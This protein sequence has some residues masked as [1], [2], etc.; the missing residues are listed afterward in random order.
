MS[1]ILFGFLISSICYGAISV[2]LTVQEALYSGGLT[3]GIAR[4]SEPITGGVPI[5]DAAGITSI[6]AF[7]LTGATAGQF[8]VEGRWPS[9]NIKW[10]KVRAIVPSVAAGG[11]ATITLTDS[12]GGNFG[13]TNLATDNGASI[14]VATGAA[15]FTVKKAQFNGLDM[16]DIGATHVVL[17]GTSDG[18]VVIGPDATAGY[19]GNV[20]CLPT[21]GGSLCTTLYKSS[22]DPNS[23]CLIEENGPAMAVLKCTADLIDSAAHVYMHLTARL[24][25]YQNK[26]YVRIT[27]ILR[28]ADYGSSGTATVASKGHQGFEL[29]VRP[30]ITGTLNYSIANHTTTPTTGALNQTGGTDN[31]YIYQAE[32]NNLKSAG[33][34][35]N[36]CVGYSSI[37]GYAIVANGSASLTGTAN[38]FPQ[39][40][41]DVSNS[42]GV[43][44]EIGQDQFSGYG[45]KS[46]EFRNGGNDVRLGIWASE[47]NTTGPAT[48]TPAAPYYMAW[49]QWSTA[50]D[51]FLNFHV[52]AVASPQNEFLKLQ[53]PLLLRA[54]YTW[55]NSSGVFPYQLPSP[56]EEDTYYSTV[57]AAASPAGPSVTA[58]DLPA[59]STSNADSL[60]SGYVCIFRF[61]SWPA[62]GGSNQMEFRLGHLYNFLRRGYTGGYLNAS[63]F[64]RWA[65]SFAFPM[66][67]GFLWSSHGPQTE[68][69]NYPCIHGT[70]S[71]CSAITSANV[72]QVSSDWVE[73]D[74]EHANIH[75]MPEYYFISGDETIKDSVVEGFKDAYLSTTSASNY[76][77]IS[78]A[79]WV[80]RSVGNV[81]KNIAHLYNFLS[82]IGDSDASTIRTN[83][84]TVYSVRL[85]PD[86]CAYTGYPSGCVPDKQNNNPNSTLQVG[87]SK[88]RGVTN[89]FKA[90]LNPGA[91][92][93]A[94]IIPAGSRLAAPF[95]NSIKL[96]GMWE[97]YQVARSNWQ[98]KNEIFDNAYGSALWA[99]NEMYVDNGLQSYVGNGFRYQAA[100]DYPNACNANDE[101]AVKNEQTVWF[102]FFIRHQ[103]EGGTSWRHKF[104][105]LLQRDLHDG[106]TDEFWYYTT[107]A[108]INNILHPN[109]NVLA[110]L[111]ITSLVDNGAGNY[112]ITWS[113]PASTQSYRIKYGAKQIVDWIGF[114]PSTY[115]FIGNPA[116]T[117]NW[118]AATDAPNIPIP[119]GTSQ[120]LTISTGV[121]GLTAANFMVKAY[122]GSG[123]TP[124]PGDTTP[125]TV[126]WTAPAGGSTLSNTVTLSATA[127]DN[128]GVSSVQ[129][130]LDGG[131][132]GGPVAGAGPSYALS[133]DTTTVSNGTHVLSASATDAA[134]NTGVSAQISITVSSTSTSPL[135]SNVLASGITTSTAGIVWTTNV[136]SDTQLAYGTTTAYGSTSP[137]N[138][139]MVT[140]HSVSLTGLAAST[141]YHFKAMSRDSQ[142]NLGSSGDFTFTTPGTGGAVSLN[143]WVGLTPHGPPAQIV[144]FDKLTYVNSRKIHCIFGNYHQA[145][146]SEPDSATVCF[147]YAENRWF[148]L[149]KNGVWHSDHMGEA[150]HSVGVW[151]YVSDQDTVVSMT[152]SSGSSSP[153]EAWLGHWWWFDVGGLTG[154]D[155]TFSPRPLPGITVPQSAM[156]YDSFNQKLVLFPDY[157]G[158]VQVCSMITN[159]CS[160]PATSGTAPG[161]LFNLS[162]AYNS[163]DHK[164]YVFGGSQNDTYT[165]NVATNAWTKQTT[166]CSGVDC[167]SNKPPAREA[168]GFAYSPVDNI[169][170]M[171]GGVFG[172]IA[173]GTALTDTWVF[174]PS[175]LQWVE[176]SPAGAY[177][178]SSVSPTFDRLTYDADSNVFILMAAGGAAPY[179]DGSWNSYTAQVFAY[180]YSAALNYERTTVPRLPP[181]GSLN[182]IAPSSATNQ[183]WAF[184]P[185]LA[186]SGSTL[187]AGWVETGAPF[188][189]S[190]CGGADHPY[191]QSISPNGT[192]AG[193]PAGSMAAACASIDPDANQNTQ[194]SSVKLAVVNGTLWEVHEKWNISGVSSSAWARQW[195][196]TAWN[197]GQVGCFTGACSGILPQRPQGLI[198]VGSTPTL[199]VIEYDRSKFMP[200]GYVRVAQWN[201]TAWVSLGTSALNVNAPGSGT[202]AGFATVASDGT[203]PAV[204]W[205]EEV[206]STQDRRTTNTTPQL[207]CKS[208]NGSQ[209]IRFGSSSL[210]QSASSWANSPAMTYLGGKYYIAWTERT[211]TGVNKLYFC[212]WDGSSCTLLGGGPL[213]INAT[214]GWAT[215]PQ[216]ANDGT[217]VYLS[218]EEQSDLGQPALAYVKQWNGS[219]ISQV[220]GVL[221]ADPINGSVEGLTVVTVQGIPTAIWGELIY[222][223]LRQVYL[224]QWDGTNW[225]MLAGTVP[226]V[227]S[228]DLNGDGSVNVL[229]VQSGINQVLG[230]TP[231]TT[232]DLQQTGQCTVVDVQRLIN[233]SLGGVC[234]LH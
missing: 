190:S 234:V 122:V 74:G 197:G 11:T 213:N 188:D 128:V 166:T 68:Y 87:T 150:G 208:W 168:A 167:T 214:T 116:T 127:S 151:T 99:I 193:L 18:F 14:T 77:G 175:T 185:T 157:N 139:S 147:S 145:L 67:D 92:G 120:S 207:Q 181:T 71:G 51:V 187:Y 231:C 225:T 30:N 162:M 117:M 102:P 66:S 15:V 112:T 6:N 132:L 53:H 59:G 57:A 56:S 96:E 98:Y 232:A 63:Y 165:F 164:V 4:T 91:A 26:T 24:Y 70:G 131:N 78:P 210:N 88:V 5:P 156:V 177:S 189:S 148:V 44:V 129:F 31:A 123:V 58:S 203:N 3:N 153:A 10:V 218:W 226:P 174:N 173:S 194:A 29:R 211:A 2:P 38:Q 205:T 105:M 229:D 161:N 40:W 19:P 176:Q 82:A 222:G 95:M 39:G 219:A 72:S 130:R 192:W 104:D 186:A 114:D 27:P 20:T 209:W 125:P 179:A 1:N 137:L 50:T 75:G 76:L 100:I 124:P 180:A 80:D 23:T 49:P 21:A 178:N 60:C 65:A 227:L 28:N 133:W 170:L 199:A 90:S 32:S 196:G 109:P 152:D 202:R 36:G 149:Q 154:R 42:A 118:F 83:G 61:Y 47:N 212:R 12:G 172:G 94:G 46:L 121:I 111:A 115:T 113:V 55:Y 182:R 43:G 143:T 106:S 183:S 216:L 136:A 41:A 198:A 204:C 171:A 89:V 52:T 155:K 160:A 119:A 37:S 16:V 146:S 107:G 163:T 233:A 81:L 103:Y 159:S 141:T 9:G 54:A 191:V 48:T 69:Y 93:C 224:K 217:N 230:I 144:G 142:G 140:A 195:N 201:G 108:V 110:T 84:E 169:F 34:C 97:F 73:P 101:F 13:G 215:H 138:S 35:G 45:N 126:T 85:H 8:M 135:I 7:G 206:N 200:E 79:I 184:D 221:N 25:F 62:A 228:C 17:S 33:W 64:Y 134:G 223:N 86:F 158:V 220:G 22:N